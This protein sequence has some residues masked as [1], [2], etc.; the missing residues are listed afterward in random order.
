[1]LER[2]ATSTRIPGFSSCEREGEG[3]SPCQGNRQQFD[4]ESRARARSGFTAPRGGRE[5]RDLLAPAAFA[6]LLLAI[7]EEGNTVSR[8]PPDS[9][10]SCA[11][12]KRG[13]GRNQAQGRPMGPTP[14][15]THARIGLAEGGK[16]VGRQG[17]FS[18]S[19]F[20]LFFLFP[21]L[22]PNKKFKLNSN[23]GFNF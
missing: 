4:A 19:A 14:P 11:N 20:V 10:T 5:S 1:L 3:T 17:G 12:R 23:S 8:D 16:G 15:V 13:H 22:F 21:V 9:E 7:G 6:L 2:P 18:P